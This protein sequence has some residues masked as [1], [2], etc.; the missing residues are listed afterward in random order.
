MCT[1]R[2]SECG[3][4]LIAKRGNYTPLGGRSC[5]EL[6]NRVPKYSL[7]KRLAK[8]ESSTTGKCIYLGVYG[9]AEVEATLRRVHLP[10]SRSQAGRGPH[11]RRAVAR[12]VTLLVGEVAFGTSPRRE[13]LRPRW[14][15]DRRARHDPMFAQAPDQ[16]V[17]DLP[18]TRVRAEASSKSSKT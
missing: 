10:S 11:G 17:R 2:W 7:H 6:V 1:F 9:T 14:F 18:V 15:A 16:A 4:S 3:L 8:P 12:G 5:R 13:V